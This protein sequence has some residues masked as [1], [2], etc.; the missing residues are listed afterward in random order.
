MSFTF[1]KAFQ[2]NCSLLPSVLFGVP[3]ESKA[4]QFIN[5]FLSKITRKVIPSTMSHPA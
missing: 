1:D 4:V 3:D 2:M 5:L